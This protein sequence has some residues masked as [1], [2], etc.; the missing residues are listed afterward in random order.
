MYSTGLPHIKLAITLI[1]MI[2]KPWKRQQNFSRQEFL[3]KKA[4]NVNVCEIC[5]LQNN[6]FKTVYTVQYFLS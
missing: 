3:G 6:S 1:I 5:A 4:K 2:T